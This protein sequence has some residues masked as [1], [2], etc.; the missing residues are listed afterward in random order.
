M[1]TEELAEQLVKLNVKII[2]LMGRN[3]LGV[4]GKMNALFTSKGCNSIF[5]GLES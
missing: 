4:C 5:I 2:I 3:A 1:P